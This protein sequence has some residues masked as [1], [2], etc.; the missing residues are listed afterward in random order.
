MNRPVEAY[1][2]PEKY[3]YVKVAVFRTHRR[4]KNG[5]EV[6]VD[7]GKLDAI[8]NRHNT[9]WERYGRASPL[10]LGHTLDGD[11]V[12]ETAQPDTAGP[13]VKFEVE[14]IPEEPDEYILWATWCRPKDKKKE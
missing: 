10:A 6:R 11:D 14:E 13:A 7:K 4:I 1:Y 9:L 2:P 3:D 8:A 5:K 12:P